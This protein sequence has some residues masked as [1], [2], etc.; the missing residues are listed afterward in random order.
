MTDDELTRRR[1]ILNLGGTVALAG[2]SG[3]V[4]DAEVAAPLPP[5]LYG[6]STDHLA[7][8]LAAK[9][10]STE[11]PYVP[12]F[13]SPADFHL[14]SHLVG[15]TLGEVASYPPVPEIARWIDLIV[16]E[17]PHVRDAA[18]A[19]TPGQRRLAVDFYG[20]QAVNQLLDTDPVSL[21]REGLKSLGRKSFLELSS[22]EQTARLEQ[23][24]AT[25]DPFFG[26]LKARIVDGFYTSKEGLKEL[27]YKGNSF[28]SESPGCDHTI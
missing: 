14:I 2:M 22:A 4:L 24:D 16:A 7:H 11:V 20:E 19:L 8:I 6:P 26:W 3:V 18:R 1:W 10:P 28:Y 15:L 17:S 23:L 5:G 9:A 13:F 21:C 27:D 12:R 25:N